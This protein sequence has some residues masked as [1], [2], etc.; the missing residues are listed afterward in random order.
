MSLRASQSF[1]L[2]S[3]EVASKTACLLPEVTFEPQ[4]SGGREATEEGKGSEGVIMPIVLKGGEFKAGW[5]CVCLT[6]G[7]RAG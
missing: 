5:T 6:L 4:R 2:W 1:I 7:G 3:S